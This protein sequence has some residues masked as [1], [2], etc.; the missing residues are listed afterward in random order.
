MVLHKPANLLLISFDQWRGDWGDPLAPVVKLPALEGLARQGWTAR[1]CYTSSPHCVPA[2]L[3]WL[4]GL[5]PSQLGVTRNIDTSLPA[6]APSIVRDLQ[7]Q[8]W[9]TALVGKTHWTSHSGKRDL[10]DDL[11]LLQALGFVEAIETSGPRA[12]RR[13]DCDLTDSWQAAGVL[14]QQ[15]AYLEARY[16]AGRTPTSWAVQPSR[17]PLELY[18]DGWITERALEQLAAMPADR[19]WL[20][21]V[22]FVGPHEPFDTPYPWHGRNRA[23]ALPVATP[24]PAWVELLPEDCEL[25]RAAASWAG[26]LTPEAVADCRADY[27]DHL[28]LLDAQ[29][30]RLLAALEQ[31]DDHG[32]TAVALTADHG[33]HL[34]DWGMLYKGTFQEGAVRVPW[35]Y[36]PPGG[37]NS[38]GPRTLAATAPATEAPLPL[39][40][41]LRHT[42][43]GLPAGGSSSRLQRWA[44]HQLGAVVEFGAELLLVQGR[45]KLVVD[46]QGRPMW[47]VHLGRD[48]GEQ[49]NVITSQPS[50]WRWS[51]GWRGLRRWAAAETVRRSEQGWLW[52]Q[53]GPQG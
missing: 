20:L 19:P 49:R 2:R 40:G 33:E 31:R 13:I 17:L 50:I 7:R 48:P 45:R 6:D 22:S 14:K 52:R 53:L 46:G 8:G 35:I 26:Q 27:A 37:V 36:R 25:R 24:L 5:E 12:L 28:Q 51:P 38:T 32:R 11:P 9:H 1:R 29:L 18:P 4:T 21:W 15:R 34:G 42:L 39:T 16:G 10:R 3:S 47:A 23:E 30:A 44:R 43:A 41:L